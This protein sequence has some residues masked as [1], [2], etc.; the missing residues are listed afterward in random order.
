MTELLF[1]TKIFSF[2]FNRKPISDY[3]EKEPALSPIDKRAKV[4]TNQKFETF[5]GVLRSNP[6]QSGTSPG[7]GRGGGG[8]LKGKTCKIRKDF[9]LLAVIS[10]YIMMEVL[11]GYNFSFCTNNGYISNSKLNLQ[12]L[13][14]KN[15][16]MLLLNDIQY[17]SQR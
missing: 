14:H 2:S 11:Q 9:Y 17:T 6:C 1:E 13:D 7:M 4:L 10:S 8:V 15:I 3:P 12:D 16:Q 5:D